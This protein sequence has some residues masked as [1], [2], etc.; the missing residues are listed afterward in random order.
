MIDRRCLHAY[1]LYYT[2][3][4]CLICYPCLLKSMM[5]R[6]YTLLQYCV[7]Y[8]QH[9]L[10]VPTYYKAFWLT[11]ERGKNGP[12]CESPKINSARI[13]ILAKARKKREKGLYS[14]RKSILKILRFILL[15]IAFSS[16]SHS[17][18]KIPDKYLDLLQQIQT[19]RKTCYIVQNCYI[20]IQNIIILLKHFIYKTRFLQRTKTRRKV[21]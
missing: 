15:L 17:F 9:C 13:L 4:I 18:Y 7:H 5:Y 21:S 14:M 19:I 3:K 1:I 11:R 12:Q 20:I 10:L 16:S 2:H 6:Y 8:E